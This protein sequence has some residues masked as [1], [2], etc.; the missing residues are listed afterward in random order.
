MKYLRVFL[1]FLFLVPTLNAQYRT[2]EQRRDSVLAF[3]KQQ[4]DFGK[5][6]P[7]ATALS[8]DPEQRSRGFRMLEELTSVTTP[9][10]VERFRMTSTYL[11]L[12]DILPDSLK[13]NFHFIWTHFPVRPF[14]GEHEKIAYYTAL[15]LATRYF[16]EDMQYFNGRSR[17]EN[18]Q[19]SRAYLLRWIKESTELGQ[20]EFDSPNYASIFFCSMLLLRDYSPDNDMR[21]R[22]E[23]MAQWLM[24]DFAHDHLNGTYG[25]A[26]AREQMASAMN[27]NSSDMTGIA[28]YY[29]ADGPIA[30]GLDQLYVALSDFR[31]HP[32]IVELATNR[33]N[34]FE[35][36]ERKRSARR[37]RSTN[38]PNEDVVRYTYMDPLYVMGSIPGGLIQPRE[39]HSW[40]VTWLAQDPRIPAT[41]FVMQPYSDAPALTPFIAHEAELA[42]RNLNSLDPYFSTITKTVGGSPFEDVYQYRNTLIALYDIGNVTRFPL[43]AGFFPPEPDILEVDT[44]HSGWITMDVGDVYIGV[45]PLKKFQLAKGMV[46][47]RFV[48]AEKRN[49]VIIQAMGRNEAGSFRQFQKRI[50]ATKPD[51]SEFDSTRRVRYTSITGHTLDFT[52][53]GDR[54]VDG[55]ILRMHEDLLFDSPWLRSMR[56]SGVLTLT[57]SNGS[58]II[59]MPALEMRT[60]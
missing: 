52:F 30:F 41:L 51:L 13:E 22:A 1:L 20:R 27:P 33:R 10:I 21:L 55:E 35:T 48:S 11:R 26:H 40:D 45:F 50:K 31:V 4:A 53:K 3:W 54:T 28:W 9:D 57:A 18:E 2:I 34:P 23:L 46:G 47:Q 38:G 32:A 24:A 14:Y 42:L 43:I 15:Y 60:E 16:P 44:L 56:G 37:I 19:D 7:A 36:W 5:Y 8:L 39:Q 49:G 25:G 12:H 58:L 6:Y 29:F 59:D 17:L